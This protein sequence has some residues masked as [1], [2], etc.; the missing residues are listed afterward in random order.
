[1][2]QVLYSGRYFTNECTCQRGMFSAASASL[3]FV[4]T[5][6]SIVEAKPTVAPA[7]LHLQLFVCEEWGLHDKIR[8]ETPIYGRSSQMN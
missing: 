5:T 6:A 7:N 8:A 1:M 4:C 3:P 2:Q